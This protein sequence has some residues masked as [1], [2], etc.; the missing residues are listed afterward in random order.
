MRA[1]SLAGPRHYIVK[2]YVGLY[3]YDPNEYVHQ[4]AQPASSNSSAW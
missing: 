1:R 2:L 3:P 4:E